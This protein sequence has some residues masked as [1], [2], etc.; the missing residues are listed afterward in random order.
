MSVSSAPCH[1]MSTASQ[2]THDVEEFSETLSK[3]KLSMLCLGQ[4]PRPYFAQQPE[5]ASKAGRRQWCFKK[6]KW[7]GNSIIFCY[8]C[9]F[10][11]SANYRAEN[12]GLEGNVKIVPFPVSS[13]SLF[14]KPR[15]RVLG[16]CVHVT[17][18]NKT[19]QISFVQCVHRS[20]KYELWHTNCIILVIPHMSSM[21]LYLHLKI[22]TA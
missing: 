10:L 21:C 12:D 7:P 4:P 2:W 8:L 3:W 20:G 11:V 6:Q 14:S 17:K 1:L 5:L 13:S 19:S 22:G 18:W 16:E 15:Q 9:Y